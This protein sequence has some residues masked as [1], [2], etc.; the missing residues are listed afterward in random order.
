MPHESPARRQ[1]AVL[2]VVLHIRAFGQQPVDAAVLLQQVGQFRLR[3]AANGVGEYRR[4]TMM[5]C[6]SLQVRILAMARRPGLIA[7][8]I[9][10]ASQLVV[11]GHQLLE[12]LVADIAQLQC[13]HGSAQPWRHRTTCARQHRRL[14]Q[15]QIR[16]TCQQ[17]R[18]ALVDADAPDAAGDRHGLLLDRNVQ[19]G[20]ELSDQPSLVK[21]PSLRVPRRHGHGAAL[22]TVQYQFT[23]V[24]IDLRRVQSAVGAQRELLV[25]RGRLDRLQFDQMLM[26]RSLRGRDRVVE[27]V[28]AALP[29]LADK[30]PRRCV[31]RQLHSAAAPASSAV[32]TTCGDRRCCGCMMPSEIR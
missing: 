24:P 30:R 3:Q 28:V 14:L 13:P 16:A 11:A 1:R 22:G 17:H 2:G 31:A 4:A 12:L 9:E 19:C 15:R 26:R 7:Q 29:A 21:T 32:P 5:D 27:P 6:Q 10:R 8:I 20:T 18:P 23:T 25:H